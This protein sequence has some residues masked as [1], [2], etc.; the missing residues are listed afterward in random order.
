M[1]ETRRRSSGNSTSTRRPRTSASSTSGNNSSENSS[2]GYTG[3]AMSRDMSTS[4]R[5][6]GRS[7]SRSSNRNEVNPLIEKLG[8]LGINEQMVEGVKT[9]VVQSVE[10]KL[11]NLDI[12]EAVE[13]AGEYAK[14]GASNVKRYSSNRPGLFYGGLLT[15]AL[16]AGLI[17]G[18][19]IER[20]YEYELSYE[21]EE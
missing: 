10:G 13:R 12:E 1:A 19:A 6:S 5:N 21:P 15:V 16:G 18:A 8:A 4:S 2:S 3:E 9:Y 20:E 14:R 7:S 17:I 11:R